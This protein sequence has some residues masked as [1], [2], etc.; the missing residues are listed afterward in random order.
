MSTYNRTGFVQY[1]YVWFRGKMGNENGARPTIWFRYV[2][3]TFT[4]FNNKDTAVQ[5]LSYLS[6][7]HTEEHSFHHWLLIA[8]VKHC[9]SRSLRQPAL[10]CL[11]NIPCRRVPHLTSIRDNWPIGWHLF[12]L[13]KLWFIYQKL[14]YLTYWR[15]LI[16]GNFFP[17]K[18]II[19][20]HR[21]IN[22]EGG[23]LTT[24]IFRC[25]QFFFDQSENWNKND[26]VM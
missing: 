16:Y 15:F 18:Y 11:T 24:V 8:F 10:L 9:W 22:Q 23:F 14:P 5:F 19:K 26:H 6:S 12:F 1:F 17:K 4:L 21:L 7:R 13:E 2:D 25:E 3:D 20:K